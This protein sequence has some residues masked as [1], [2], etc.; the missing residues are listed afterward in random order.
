MLVARHETKITDTTDVA[1][2]PEFADRKTTKT[3]DGITL[4]GWYTEDFTLRE[5]STLRAKE[6]IPQIRQHNTM[7]D[8]RYKI[9]TFQEVIEL[10]ARLSRS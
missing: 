3:I 5:L 9:P 4:T 6:R 8:G 7:Y 1:N 2:H 10:R